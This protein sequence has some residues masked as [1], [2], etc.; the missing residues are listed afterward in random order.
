MKNGNPEKRSG[1]SIPRRKLP[2]K[3]HTGRASRPEVGRD[4]RAKALD[5]VPDPR[6]DV[7]SLPCPSGI[8]R[9]A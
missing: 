2:V 9:P 1:A 7:D 6:G 4:A 3:K 5:E 8:P